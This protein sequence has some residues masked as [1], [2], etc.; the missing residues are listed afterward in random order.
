[1][2]IEFLFIKLQIE[3]LGTPSPFLPFGQ[4]LKRNDD[5]GG[6]RAKQGELLIIFYLKIDI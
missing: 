3:E 2:L 6:S 1:M 4:T 5:G